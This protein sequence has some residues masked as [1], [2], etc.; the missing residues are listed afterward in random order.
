MARRE[1]QSKHQYDN[2]RRL[3]DFETNPE[4]AK[5]LKSHVSELLDILDQMIGGLA[6]DLEIE[7]GQ[8]VGKGLCHHVGSV[9]ITAELQ[10]SLDRLIAE[11]AAWAIFTGDSK[12][13]VARAMRKNSSNL[14][15]R[16]NIGIDIE[17]LISAWEQATA[18]LKEHPNQDK[19]KLTVNLHDGYPYEIE[20]NQA[21]RQSKHADEIEENSD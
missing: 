9:L 16:S 15:N 14:Y 4:Y 11:Q 13:S 10:R 6:Q 17:R 5:L 7:T 2:A 1:T 18:Y 8:G 21:I 20:V 3:H 19:W 12:G